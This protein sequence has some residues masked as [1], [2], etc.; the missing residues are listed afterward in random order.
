LASVERID[1]HHVES[2]YA[3]ELPDTKAFNLL[4]LAALLERKGDVL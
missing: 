3:H 1:H 2:E 4:P